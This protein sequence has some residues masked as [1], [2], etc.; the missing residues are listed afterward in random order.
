MAA[1]S[2]SLTQTPRSSTHPPDVPT[3]GQQAELS[4]NGNYRETQVTTHAT[5]AGAGRARCTCASSVHADCYAV[6]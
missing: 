4:T 2:S 5:G 3:L 1:E 6:Y